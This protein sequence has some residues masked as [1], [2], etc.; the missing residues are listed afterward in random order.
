MGGSGWG[1]RGQLGAT[2]VL[3]FTGAQTSTT[4]I[5]YQGQRRMTSVVTMA[6][7]AGVCGQAPTNRSTVLN[8]DGTGGL[9]IMCP[10]DTL[11]IYLPQG[12]SWVPGAVASSAGYIA[13]N[14]IPLW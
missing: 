13:L 7:I 12:G 3:H 2:R 9:M 11:T 1:P 8:A 6:M 14:Q 5:W 10:G 4:L